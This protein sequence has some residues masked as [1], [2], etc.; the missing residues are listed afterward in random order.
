MLQLAAP[1]N[2]DNPLLLLVAVPRDQ[3]RP[4]HSSGAAPVT[5]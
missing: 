4:L 2:N 1:R 3:L 5:H